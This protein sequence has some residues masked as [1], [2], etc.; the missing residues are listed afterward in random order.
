MRA[1]EIITLL[2]FGSY[3]F[4][5]SCTGDKKND[6][7]TKDQSHDLRWYKQFGLPDPEPDWSINEYAYAVQLLSGLETKY[8][9]S[10]PRLHSK[11]SG[12]I[13]EKLMSDK[14]FSFLNDTLSLREKAR[15]L[16]RFSNIYDELADLYYMPREETQYYN[17]EL[18]EIYLFGLKLSQH[19][20]DVG[21]QIEL[22]PN[23]SL[24]EFKAG[25]FQVRDSYIVLTEKIIR[26]TGETNAYAEKD[27][28]KLAGS[29]SASIR[30]NLFWMNPS[31]KDIILDAL[32]KVISETPS[33]SIRKT[34]NEIRDNLLD[35]P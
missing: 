9:H 25:L 13:F 23:P 14:N 32:N 4:L 7:Q 15:T 29:I 11:K 12:T 19:M 30:K 27:L 3:L 18:V 33:S 5:F 35:K 1:K 20:L 10:L 34:Y 2:F 21:R 26:L 31:Q 22:A 6:E 24:D 8:P 17:R 16:L 28:V